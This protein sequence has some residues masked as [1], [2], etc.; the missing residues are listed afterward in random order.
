[1]IAVGSLHTCRH[2]SAFVTMRMALTAHR[3]TDAYVQ[4]TQL[5]H[6]GKAFAWRSRHARQ[7]ACSKFC[8]T[9]ESFRTHSTLVFSERPE[10]KYL[11]FGKFARVLWSLHKVTSITNPG[12]TISQRRA[13]AGRATIAHGSRGQGD[14]R[15]V[16]YLACPA[17]V[18]S[19]AR[20]RS[21]SLAIQKNEQDC[22]LNSDCQW[23]SD[24]TCPEGAGHPAVENMI[25]ESRSS[26]FFDLYTV[27]AGSDADF[28][29]QFGYMKDFCQQA[30]DEVTCAGLVAENI[31]E[32]VRGVSSRA[33][34]QTWSAAILILLAVAVKHGN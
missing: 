10:R 11:A 22:T 26:A 15:L 1:M 16:F 27:A 19:G 18:T 3:R 25:C 32:A 13:L 28:V 7:L 14:A 6:L 34:R 29:R 2:W 4:S 31:P 33:W 20:F 24:R 9:A 17:R 12:A 5:P 21:L 8:A 23:V 30:E